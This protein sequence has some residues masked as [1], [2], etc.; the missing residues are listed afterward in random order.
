M[1]IMSI[2][3]N[4]LIGGEHNR[5]KVEDW[6]INDVR[7]DTWVWVNT[8]LDQGYQLQHNPW[9]E[10]PEEQNK[11]FEEIAKLAYSQSTTKTS[12]FH[13]V[14]ITMKFG[15]N[16]V[17]L[18]DMLLMKVPNNS[19]NIII[20]LNFPYDSNI[21]NENMPKI[22]VKKDFFKKMLKSYYGNN[23][24]EAYINSKYDEIIQWL[25]D[26]NWRRDSDA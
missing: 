12:F 14:K 5:R 9:S 18:L 17:S 1:F 3:K 16:T 21:R 20:H 15:E 10:N 7:S 4:G 22:I 23:K 6:D 2:D 24:D 26:D 13:E 8:L 19:D 25:R 11:A